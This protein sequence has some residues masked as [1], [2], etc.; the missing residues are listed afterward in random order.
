M[1]SVQ[2]FTNY[3]QGNR[4]AGGFLTVADSIKININLLKTKTGG[5]FVSFPSYQKKDG[6]W[7]NYVDTVSKE[8]REEITRAVIN[9]YERIT[10]TSRTDNPEDR[11]VEVQQ[12]QSV[13]EVQTGQ[14]GTPKGRPF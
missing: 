11:R 10:G 4:I 1:Y 5:Y 8:A 13:P 7:A 12:P 3:A 6:T 2:L 9:A 14:H